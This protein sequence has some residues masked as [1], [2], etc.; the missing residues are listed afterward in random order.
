MDTDKTEHRGSGGSGGI[1]GGILGGLGA[2]KAHDHS[3]HQ[4]RP[5]ETDQTAHHGAGTLGGH[6]QHGHHSQPAD[7]R[8]AGHQKTGILGGILGSHK[9]HDHPQ[10]HDQ[11]T[12]VSGHVHPDTSLHDRGSHHNRAADVNQPAYQNT[13]TFSGILG[14][15]ESR[16]RPTHQ[17]HPTVV[18]GH[19]ASGTGTSGNHPDTSLRTHHHL[20]HG[21]PSADHT[22]GSDRPVR[23]GDY[24]HTGPSTGHSDRPLR[25]GDHHHTGSST[26]AGA[27]L[28]AG[29][30][31]GG[32]RADPHDTSTGPASSTAGPHKSNVLNK[33]DPRVDS[34]LDGSRTFGSVPGTAG[35]YDV[36]NTGDRREPHSTGLTRGGQ[37]IVGREPDSSYGST[38]AGAYDTG[39]RHGQ[40]GHPTSAVSSDYGGTMAPAG[41]HR[42]GAAN[43][44]DPRVDLDYP[45]TRTTAA[46]PARDDHHYG[47]D[48][49]MAG[50]A[51]AVGGTAL[52]GSDRRHQSPPAYDVKDDSYRHEDRLAHH[53]KDKDVGRYREEPHHTTGAERGHE[54][55]KGGVLGFL[56]RD[57]DDKGHGAATHKE[58]HDHDKSVGHGDGKVDLL[59]GTR[60]KD[61]EMYHGEPRRHGASTPQHIQHERNL[62]GL[63][64]IGGHDGDRAHDKHRDE[65]RHHD[66]TTTHSTAKDD[67]HD[68]DHKGGILGGLLSHDK[69][70]S[71]DTTSAHSTEHPSSSREASIQQRGPTT[72]HTD[73][74]G[75]TRL[76]KD[77]P[78]LSGDEQRRR[79]Q[80]L[81][82]GV[83]I[84]PHTGLPMDVG[85]YGTS[86]AGGTDNTPGSG[87]HR[88]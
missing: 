19:A 37:Q 32:S 63:G 2:K 52:H 75:R 57:K 56:H 6:D 81:P 71:K 42:S 34:D 60:D 73:R 25:D 64:L 14:S 8:Q 69:S 79:Q 10:H 15:S 45:G 59:G 48:A 27:G 36:V 17:D 84:E 9:S 53:G 77:N 28:A 80:G 7:D 38:G 26:A 54:Q 66:T 65:R 50:G 39:A 43:T 1:L 3:S 86:G 24:H 11:S 78:E 62:E 61:A 88:H 70:K 12:P 55:K 29:A 74:D 5:M 18:P 33:L 46:A 83:V 20:G 72:T 44:I 85:K 68:R 41:P 16:D 13:K 51:A 49:A 76:H 31:A 67:H 40:H 30:L 21:L 23:E 22:H 47:R 58:H 35:N 82:E 87:Y 4:T